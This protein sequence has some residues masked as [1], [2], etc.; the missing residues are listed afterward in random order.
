MNTAFDELAALTC[1]VQ[2]TPG[3]HPTRAFETHVATRGVPTR[4]HHGF[5]YAARKRPVWSDDGRCLV[6]GEAHSVHPPQAGSRAAATVAACGLARWL[7]PLVT[8]EG[9][10]LL[11]TMYPGY[12]LGSGA[13]IDLAMELGV[14]LAVDV[15]HVFMQLAQGAM[16]TSTWDRLA[17]YERIGEVHVSA[18]DGTRDAHAPLEENAFGLGWARERMARDT[19]VVLECYMHRLG[20]GERRSQLEILDPKRSAS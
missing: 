13:E 11:E 19:P 6:R 9:M 16:A 10:P 4:L 17:R 18:N 12:V 2:L 20:P 14:R 3:N 5:A 1:A 8:S 7:E 15:S